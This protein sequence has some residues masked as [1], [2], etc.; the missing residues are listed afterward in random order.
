MSLPDS[1]IS[2]ARELP[3]VDADA[4]LAAMEDTPS[5]GVRLNPSKPC[6]L[7]DGEEEVAW[8]ESGRYLA[9]R[10]QFTLMPE[11]H[12]GAFYVQDPSSMIHQ[13]II[14]QIAGR[15]TTLLDLC[16]APGGKTTACFASL[17]EGC[18]AVANEVVPARARILQENLRKWG[19]PDVIVTS[20]SA[21]EL[22]KIQGHFDIIVAD[23]PC[24]G[25]GMMRKDEEARRQWN[26]GL[27]EQCAALQRKIVADIMPAL[28]PGGYLV[29]STCTFNM[30]E[31]E[32]NV[33]HFIDTYGLE[34][35]R[36]DVDKAWGIGSSLDYGIHALR[37]MPHLTRGEGLFVALLRKPQD[38]PAGRVAYGKPARPEK[39]V[40]AEWVK[41]QYNVYRFGTRLR[42]MS[43]ACAA[44]LSTMAG[45]KG[46]IVDA[47][48]E[49][50]EIKGRDI[51]PS[52]ALPL[53]DAYRRGA[54]PE[55]ELDVAEA[56]AFL[57]REP[58]VLPKDT[59]RGYIVIT[60][61]SL[62]LGIVKNLGSRINNLYPKE[63]R[64]RI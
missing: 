38:A 9:E 34:S 14:A 53:S 22:G 54:L 58:L 18:V 59:P 46:A 63:W 36:I 7:F 30:K 26:T 57:R 6:S 33:R 24:S 62:P 43:A 60:H 2:T 29:Y 61:R 1:F 19:R 17:P 4:F 31:N 11:L 64:I 55:A 44:L 16:A 10:P 37:F 23:V 8:C 52:S 56:L 49:I 50:G 20:A 40:A 41:P 42:A 12:A 48:T 27:T 13:H 21:A 25:E 5:V 28:A 39:T 45:V 15:G 51:V 3:G 47:G 35:V 32:E